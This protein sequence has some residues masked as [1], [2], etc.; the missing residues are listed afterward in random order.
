MKNRFYLFPII[1]Y[2]LS[3]VGCIKSYT[4]IRVQHRNESSYVLCLHFTITEVIIRKRSTS[5][6]LNSSVIL[7]DNLSTNSIGELTSNSL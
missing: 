3:N 4:T 6:R 1:S 7:D 2:N 5:D